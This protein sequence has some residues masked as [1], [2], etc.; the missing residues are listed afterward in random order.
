VE[1]PKQVQCR[2]LFGGTYPEIF[3]G[4]FANIIHG[5]S[6]SWNGGFLKWWYP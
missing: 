6:W 2:E 4:N 1:C 5:K 3:R